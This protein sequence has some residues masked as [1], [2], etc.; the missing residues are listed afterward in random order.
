MT[1]NQSMT[2]FVAEL[3]AAGVPDPLAQPLTLALVWA[4]LARLAGESVPADAA[5]LLDAPVPV[6]CL[7]PVPRCATLR[8][9]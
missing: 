3:T 5:T 8:A 4:D 1:I 7:R 9:E 6:R 2:A